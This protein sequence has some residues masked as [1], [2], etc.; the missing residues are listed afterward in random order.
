MCTILVVE[1][2]PGVLL[3]IERL[4]RGAPYLVLTA[5]SA[6]EALRVLGE[7]GAEVDL[8]LTDVMLGD[9]HGGDLARRALEARPGCG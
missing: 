9:T 3:L 2:D 8:L 4:L 6:A 1:D 7:R 5:G